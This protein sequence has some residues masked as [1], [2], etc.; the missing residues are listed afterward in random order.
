MTQPDADPSPGLSYLIP[1]YNEE[2]SIGTTI[3][4]LKSILSTLDMPW[5]IVIINDGSRDG[6]LAAAQAHDGVRVVSHP[7][8]IGYGSALK[9]GI[10][11]ARHQWIGIV[12]A[13]DTYD[14]EQIPTLVEQMRA[15]FDMVVAARSNVLDLDRPVK[16]QF[17]RLLIAFLNLVIGA[18]IEDPNSGFRIFTRDLAMTFFPFLCNTFS[19]TTSLTVFALG[20][21]YFVKYVP[22]PYFKR[23]GKS[24]VRHFR[25]SLRMMQLV[26]QG[27]T[28][29]NPIKFYL[30]M[31]VGLLVGFLVP[32]AILLSQ[33]A[34]P[35]A[36]LW[37]GFGAVSALMIGLG[38]LGDII[39]ISAIGRDKRG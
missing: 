16:R 7:T 9:A 31:V 18:R 36:A 10:C 15:G 11:A 8:N 35:L 2:H 27:I 1:A 32:S 5:E 24:K 3:E 30:M 20:E 28:F 29:F 14:I 13:D 34:G 22:L 17:R 38:V 39:R 12:D 19:F 6:T 26:L 23:S 21:R 25:D 4:R 37:F 33:G